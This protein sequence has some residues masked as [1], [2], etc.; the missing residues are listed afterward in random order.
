[1]IQM[2]Q[3]E[4]YETTQSVLKSLN[5]IRGFISSVESFSDLEDMFQKFQKCF[6]EAKEAEAEK[7]KQEQERATQA[8]AVKAMLDDMG[9]SI[10][11]FNRLMLRT[12]QIGAVTL[13][14]IQSEEKTTQHKPKKAKGSRSQPVYVFQYTENGQEVRTPL[15]GAVGRK[16]QAMVEQMEAANLNP[17]SPEDCLVLAVNPTKEEVDTYILGGGRVDL[18]QYPESVADIAEEEVD[19]FD[20]DSPEENF[21]NA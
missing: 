5:T 17:Y 3:H 9:L 8:M 6:E 12:G 21:G 2:T 20:V 4:K 11:E 19:E 18:I 10:E 7:I 1:M 13:S 15:R 14:D 16:P